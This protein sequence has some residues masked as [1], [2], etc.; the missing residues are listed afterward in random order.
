[1]FAE[2]VQGLSKFVQIED[3]LSC[4]FVVTMKSCEGNFYEVYCD[5]QIRCWHNDFGHFMD[6]VIIAMM[7]YIMFGY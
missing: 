5:E 4:D 7:F 1:M 2:C 6:I 3:A